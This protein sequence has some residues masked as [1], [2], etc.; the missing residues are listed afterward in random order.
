LS[1]QYLLWI[2]PLIAY[3]R[4]PNWQWIALWGAVM[5]LTVLSYPI[6]YTASYP[7]S[8][9]IFVFALLRGSL[10]LGFVITVLWKSIMQPATTSLTKDEEYT[11]VDRAEHLVG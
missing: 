5:V 1:P 3:V 4:K 2:I 9:V 10:L 7:P 11:P 8:R 6:T